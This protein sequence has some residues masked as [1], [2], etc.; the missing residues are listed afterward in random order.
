MKKHIP[1]ALT[2]ALSLTAM[3]QA[4]T[5]TVKTTIQAAIDAAKPGDTIIV[6]PG[7]YREN[8]TVTKD[9]LTIVGSIAAILDGHGLPGTTGIRVA[10]PTTNG[11]LHGFTLRGLTIR[12]YSRTGIRLTRV[13]DFEV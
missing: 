6:P 11:R 2:L 4:A 13:D 8:V 5:I 9:N 12:N 3:A 1:L 10:P 7:T